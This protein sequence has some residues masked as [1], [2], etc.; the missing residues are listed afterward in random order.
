MCKE[1]DRIVRSN[2]LLYFFLLLF[3]IYLFYN[4]QYRSLSIDIQPD[5]ENP[6]VII[7]RLV[8]RWFFLSEWIGNNYK[9]KSF[10]N[11]KSSIN[12]NYYFILFVYYSLKNNR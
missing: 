1:R 4:N 7:R 11:I 6:I 9:V 10:F 8:K 3:F 2:K 12:S 5:K